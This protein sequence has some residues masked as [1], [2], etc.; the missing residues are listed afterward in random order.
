MHFWA[1]Q[2]DQSWVWPLLQLCGVL[3]A[4]GAE[5]DARGKDNQTPLHWAALQ[6]HFETCHFLLHEGASIDAMDEF[7]FTPVLRAAQ[8]GGVKCVSQVWTFETPSHSLF[9]L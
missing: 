3:L 2:P 1:N 4:A 6:G 9:F 7:G 8:V 5:I